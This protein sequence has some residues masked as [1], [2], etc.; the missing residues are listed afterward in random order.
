MSPHKSPATTDTHTTAAALLGRS[1]G[2]PS[3]VFMVLAAA[4]PLAVV[5]GLVPIVLAT[6]GTT[7]APVFYLLS[8]AVLLVFS[9]GFTAMSRY[10]PNAG[11]FYTY[12]QTGLGRTVGSG[13]AILSLVTYAL[14]LVS[15]FF[16]VGGLV[17]DTLTRYLGFSPMPWWAWALII[18]ALVGILGYRDIDLSAKVLTAL[19]GAEVAAVVIFDMG[20]LLQGGSAG[21][22]LS[23]LNV[24]D[25][26]GGSVGLGLMFAFL[27]F[28]GF[29]ATAVFRNEARDPDRTIPRATYIAVL[30]I[31]FFYAFSA[32]M[33]VVGQGANTAVSA[34]V[35]DPTGM[36]PNLASRFVAPILSDVISVLMVTSFIAAVLAFHNI[37]NRYA[38]TLGQAGL[39][40]RR[41]AAVHPRHRA[42]SYSSL[43]FSVASAVFVIVGLLTGLDPILQIYTW[44]SGAATLGIVALMTLTSVAVLVF[45]RRFPQPLS[46]WRTLVA[47]A[48][49]VLG[50]GAMLVII[51]S[52][53]E[54]LV[55]S[56]LAATILELIMLATFVAG[57]VIAVVYRVRRPSAYAALLMTPLSSQEQK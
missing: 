49:A 30:G 2:V 44:L 48:G 53:Y 34:A 45:F 20:I 55:V 7:S 47:P 57:V 31:G 21:L 17:A 37:V 4:A 51:V 54:Q 18:V 56:T 15:G 9:V 41:L 36:V 43:I 33:V 42:P 35:D 11:A 3:I 5:G 46:A 26:G 25:I 27:G 1:L 29:E 22:S 38:L 50:L 19:L 6:S 10:V 24:A 8:A 23:P 52:N 28:I 12:I 40:P 16:Y 14:L 13:A 32:W 39:L